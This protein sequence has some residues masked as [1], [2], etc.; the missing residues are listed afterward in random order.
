MNDTAWLISLLVLVYLSECVGWTSH[1][2]VLFRNPLAGRTR[3][4]RF[5]SWKLPRFG[6]RNSGLYVRPILPPLGTVF[7]CPVWT[8]SLSPA[9]ALAWVPFAMDAHDRPDQ[10]ATFISWEEPEGSRTSLPAPGTDKHARPQRIPHTAAI[11]PDNKLFLNGK[12]FV[13]CAT[14]QQTRHFANLA[15]QIQKAPGVRAREQII[16][17]QWSAAL[18]S[19][20]LARRIDQFFRQTFWLRI[21]TNLLFLHALI[22]SPIAVWRV[23]LLHTWIPLLLILVA[24]QTAC[25]GLFFR[26]HRQWQPDLKSER[27]RRAAI[28]LL[29]PPAAIRALDG[30]AHEHLIGFHPL[31]VAHA[32]L[33][34]SQ[35]LDFARRYLLDL[36]H[37]MPSQ[38]QAEAYAKVTLQWH[39]RR[40]AIHLKRFLQSRHIA[41]ETLVASD[42]PADDGCQSYCPRCQCQYVIPASATSHCSLCDIPL[43]AF[44]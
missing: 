7:H 34:E 44:E 23:G 16:D 12:F 32:T 8:A 14:A 11:T 6:N 36:R 25:C 19:T 41:I 1:H 24:L 27:Y 13:R 20:T 21:F 39:M 15:D 33:I 2:T 28:L 43:V 4:G 10:S 31:A 40:E 5:W 30:L 9:G 35:F 38:I 3:P 26:I 42:P 18:D 29:S 22:L 37:A 17:A